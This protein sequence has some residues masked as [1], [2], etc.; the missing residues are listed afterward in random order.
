ML[1]AAAASTAPAEATS[2]ATPPSS[3]TE[4]EAAP[5]GGPAGSGAETGPSAPPTTTPPVASPPVT[6]P[7]TAADAPAPAADA[8][9]AAADA[10]APA[11]DAPA[12]AADAQAPPADAPAPAGDAPSPV[13]GS[14]E[15]P[16]APAAEESVEHPA[17]RRPMLRKPLLDDDLESPLA[18]AAREKPAPE[19]P[20]R[21]KPAEPPAPTAAAEPEP[22]EVQPAVE[23]SGA[24]D[25]SADDEAAGPAAE[26]E[27]PQSGVAAAAATKA[28]RDAVSLSAASSAAFAAAAAWAAA[29]ES[30]N[31]ALP[32]PPP[33]PSHASSS[34]PL[35]SEAPAVATGHASAGEPPVSAGEPPVPAG[36]TSG[37]ATATSA[38]SS[39]TAPESPIAGAPAPPPAPGS[40]G[41][42]PAARPVEPLTTAPVEQ[43]TGGLARP[44]GTSPSSSA[45]WLAEP[46]TPGSAGSTARHAPEAADLG[47]QPLIIRA[48][49]D[50]P[51]VEPPDETATV[52]WT[53]KP[54][55]KGPTDTPWVEPEIYRSEIE[56]VKPPDEL[57]G[58]APSGIICSA[59]GTENDTSRRFCRSCGNP[60]FAM[61]TPELEVE[62]PKR[63][64]WRWLAILVPILL[65]AGIL[66]FVGAAWL[67]G[68]LFA[69][70][71]PIPS[72]VP[73]TATPGGPQ[74]SSGQPVVQLKVASATAS[75]KLGDQWAP[76][77]AIDG[78]TNTSWQEGADRVAGQWL[79]V[80]FRNPVTVA[81]ITIW[82][83]SQTAEANYYGNLRP[84][85]ITIAADGGPGQ[86]FELAD[87]FEP[88]VI[89]YS[90]PVTSQLRI[91]IN[92]TYPSKKTA[93]PNSPFPDCAISELRFTGTVP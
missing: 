24:T 53:P 67:R 3:P 89:A 13:A 22:D 33:G 50:P 14:N 1:P 16:A 86:K 91:T 56:V 20:A 88:Q 79:Q 36:Q 46:E 77:K 5:A 27:A 54:G 58:P 28:N 32:G 73:A 26:E 8:P 49:S 85:H 72:F 51:W 76:S 29:G 66:G 38:L 44:A 17:R 4:S 30:G 35:P 2:K 78:K 43:P 55:T 70:A 21:E 82:A 84:R 60:L 65:V 61:E 47:R 93:L 83:G 68:G 52:A 31:K 39:G 48:S 34:S 87:R 45:P 7:A 59:C 23:A 71:S 81:S 6:D 74:P 80:A 62:E 15:Q 41:W 37:G 57:G 19:K 69:A 40:P 10:P 92:D 90:G 63:R 64:S 11:A 42:Q 75:S 18:T 25:V 12:A 9:A